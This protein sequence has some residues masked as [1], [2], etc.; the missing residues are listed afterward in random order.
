MQSDHR[1]S[2]DAPTPAQ[3]NKIA[4]KLRKR[5]AGTSLPVDGE[6]PEENESKVLNSNNL[7]SPGEREASGIEPL[8]L[9][10]SQGGLVEPA[11][12]GSGSK[13]NSPEGS[14]QS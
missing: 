6:D 14:G 8:P 9:S 2:F 7:Q 3:W 12:E 5:A 13:Q 1:A 11:G 10:P 4:S